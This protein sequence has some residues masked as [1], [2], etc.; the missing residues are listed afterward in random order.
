[1]STTW[2]IRVDRS[3]CIGSGMCAAS[4]PAHFELGEDRK[5]HPRAGLVDRDD[6]VLDAAL[7]CPVEA[8]TVSDHATGAV[9][10]PE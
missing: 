5:S 9:M 8:I 1:M 2:D 6:G 3:R 10:A 4:D 7:N